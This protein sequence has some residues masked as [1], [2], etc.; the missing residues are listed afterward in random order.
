MFTEN[1]L[2]R[3][4]INPLFTA[5]CLNGKGGDNCLHCTFLVV[6]NDVYA[7]SCSPMRVKVRGAGIDLN[8]ILGDELHFG[9]RPVAVARPCRSAPRR[10]V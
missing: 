7:F 5:C 4:A 6:N 9:S 2:L 8:A 10:C 3:C 1:T